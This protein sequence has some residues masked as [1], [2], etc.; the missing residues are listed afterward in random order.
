[1]GSGEWALAIA[2]AGSAPWVASVV[3]HLIT[4]ATDVLRDFIARGNRLADE[5]RDASADLVPK[6]AD[7]ERWATPAK[8]DPF[9]SALG[10]VRAAFQSEEV[11][12]RCDELQRLAERGPTAEWKSKKDELFKAIDRARR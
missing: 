7:F 2:V 6:C 1:M 4:N 10:R 3:K 11:R 5:R 12:S 8:Q 9:F